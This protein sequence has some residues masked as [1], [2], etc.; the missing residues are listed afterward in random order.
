VGPKCSEVTGSQHGRESAAVERAPFVRVAACEEGAWATQEKRWRGS[1][2]VQA[3][4][5]PFFSFSHFC[6]LFFLILNFKFEFQFYYG[7]HA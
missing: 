3:R 4:F 5:S 6:F 2:G 7:V 1:F